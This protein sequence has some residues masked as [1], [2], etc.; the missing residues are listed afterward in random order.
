MLQEL[1][2]RQRQIVTFIGKYR[3]QHGCAPLTKEV[4]AAL[5]YG[6]HGMVHREIAKCVDKGVLTWD[7]R[8]IRT[9]RIV[10]HGGDFMMWG[11]V[12]C[13]EVEGDEPIDTANFHTLTITRSSLSA[14]PVCRT[15]ASPL[16]RLEWQ[17]RP[18][19]VDLPPEGEK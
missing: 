4:S 7:R 17:Q 9:V 14:R 8:R 11:C 12:S 19:T 2:P 3:D 10:N 18:A 5:G 15:C 6:S 1:T 16:E 13:A